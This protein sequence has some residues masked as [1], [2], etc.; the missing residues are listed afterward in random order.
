MAAIRSK[1]TGPELLLRQALRARGLRGYRC[2]LKT[3]PGKPDIAFTRWK[4]AIFV[5]GAFWHGHP[6]H[7]REGTLSDY[8]DEKIRRT[9]ERD[10]AQA[11]ELE[12]AGYAVLRFWDFDVKES[13]DRCIE[14]VQRAM[15]EQ[16]WSAVTN[17]D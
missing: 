4:V 14:S 12:E 13:V 1:N 11:A 9:K 6:D 15:A 16:G 5:D 7:F 2:N 3:L 8:W 17:Q 10:R